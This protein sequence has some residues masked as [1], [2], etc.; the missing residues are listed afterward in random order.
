MDIQNREAAARQMQLR[1]DALRNAGV[2]FLP[3]PDVAVPIPVAT[4]PPN[5]AVAGPATGNTQMLEAAPDL[6]ERASALEVLRTEVHKCMACAEL[7]STRSQTVFGVGPM[8]VDL[9]FVGEAPGAD[10]DRQGMP[11][12]GAAGQLLTRIIEAM[13]LRRDDVYICNILKCRPPGNRQPLPDEAAN[14]RR[15]LDRQLELIQ[16]RLICCLGATASQYLLHETTAIGK[17]RGRFY[18]YHGIPVLC[19]YHPASLLPGRSPQNKGLVWHDMKLLLQRLG[20]PVP[21]SAD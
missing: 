2:E 17:M 12:V 20:R 7:C 19:T 16:P 21:T 6:S 8:D 10:E 11:F 14:C 13:G 9:C 18:D 1:I 3:A 5:L 4:A 15:F